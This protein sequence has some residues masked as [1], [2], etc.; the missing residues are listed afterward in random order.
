MTKEDGSTNWKHILIGKSW[1]GFIIA[2][3]FFLAVLLMAYGYKR[4][5]SYCR[6]FESN[7]C[8][9]CEKIAHQCIIDE[10]QDP[11]I[12][13]GNISDLNLTVIDENGTKREL[14]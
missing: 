1:K 14:G 5:V 3:I 8:I 9:Y 13:R 6:E 7:P 2:T 10:S 4:D 12:Y 11:R